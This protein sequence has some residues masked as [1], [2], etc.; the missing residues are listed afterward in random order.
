MY[1]LAAVFLRLQFPHR[2]IEFAKAVVR[3]KDQSFDGWQMLGDAQALIGA[4]DAAAEAYRRA[5]A[6]DPLSGDALAGLV[7]VGRGLDGDDLIAR[8]VRRSADT[9]APVRD[10]IAASFA[11]GG[12]YDRAKEYDRAFD[13]YALAN[14]LVRQ[15]RPAGDA[16]ETLTNLR[17][18]VDWS[19]KTFDEETFFDAMAFGNMS[20]VPVFIVGMPR[21]GTTLV[22]QIAASHPSV[23]GLGE[24]PDIANMLGMVTGD[25]TLVPPNA[26]DE[27][28]I[29]AKT[30]AMIE[31][32][33]TS[34]PSAQRVIK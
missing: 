33:T 1:K 25:R 22:E 4:F 5:L 21:S 34:F 13:A 28:D 20:N 12:A 23:V 29:P 11:L 26:W 8:A 3:L 18:I 16:E 17:E 14:R 31:R 9:A 30:S 10:R 32:F 27:R 19:L 15:I 24:R 6:I 2:T 7:K